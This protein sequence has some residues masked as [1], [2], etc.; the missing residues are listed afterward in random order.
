MIF[1]LIKAS[2][3][4]TLNKHSFYPIPP[5]HLLG[6]SL[7][8]ASSYSKKQTLPNRPPTWHLASFLSTAFTKWPFRLVPQESKG[9]SAQ[10]AQPPVN[11]LLPH[12][13]DK[14]LCRESPRCA[15]AHQPGNSLQLRYSTGLSLGSGNT[16]FIAGVWFG[17]LLFSFFQ[18]I[19]L[20]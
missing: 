7:S 15:A 2:S 1:K 14:Q 10:R 4:T 16:S 17:G 5:P 12:L 18:V 11:H 3:N 13:G 20:F 6:L 8:A 19:Q 9:L